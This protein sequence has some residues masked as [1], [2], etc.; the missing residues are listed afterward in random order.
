MELDEDTEGL[1]ATVYLLQQQLKEAREQLSAREAG[2]NDMTGG[3]NTPTTAE[4]P[5]LTIESNPNYIVTATASD[6]DQ[7]VEKCVPSSET[8]VTES[9]ELTSNEEYIDIKVVPP[10]T[11][12]HTEMVVN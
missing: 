8:I 1:Q 11:N 10:V 12:G 4:I 7:G 9:Q 3:S 6:T 2:V 5:Q